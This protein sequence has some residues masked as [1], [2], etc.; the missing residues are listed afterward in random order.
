MATLKDTT[1]N[2]TGYIR[3]PVGT[4][5]Q[6]PGSPVAGMTRWNSDLGYEEYYNGTTWK[7]Q[8]T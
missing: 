1:I 2:D 3:I 4:T 7:R 6:R 8:G 5:A